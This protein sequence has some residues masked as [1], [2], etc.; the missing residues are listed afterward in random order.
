VV[1]R[2]V[3]AGSTRELEHALELEYPIDVYSLSHVALPFPMSDGLYGLRPDPSEDFG[4][5]L[6][7]TAAR[8]EIG[9]LVVNMN[10]MLRMSSNPF[11][12]FMLERI[13]EIIVADLPAAAPAAA[14]VP[15]TETGS[16]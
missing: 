16:P 2:V 9:A 15:A 5:N 11:F 4:L 7:T 10:A 12:P 8:G 6:G 3:E 1:K 14:A 13:D